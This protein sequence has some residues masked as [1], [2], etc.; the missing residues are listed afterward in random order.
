MGRIRWFGSPYSGGA[1]LFRMVACESASGERR[2]FFHFPRRTRND[3]FPLP[4][5]ALIAP[6]GICVTVSH[7][8]GCRWNFPEGAPCQFRKKQ[9]RPPLRRALEIG[10]AEHAS[11]QPLDIKNRLAH[12]S[13]QRAW[14]W[15]LGAWAV[16]R[17]SLQ[18]P[19]RSQC[20]CQSV[21]GL[22][23]IDRAP[24]PGKGFHA[25]PTGS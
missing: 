18:Q 20:C 19:I 1:M 21:V 16:S 4:N 25:K 7:Q 5:H 14:R 11:F 23:K 6:G 8:V 3:S 2:H 9:H 10:L 17:L 13:D 24:F 22:Q 12:H 15:W